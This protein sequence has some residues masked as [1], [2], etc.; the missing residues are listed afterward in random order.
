MKDPQSNKAIYNNHINSKVWLWCLLLK[1][2]YLPLHL[3]RRKL[4]WL[5]RMKRKRR[6]RMKKR[7]RR[8]RERKKAVF[9]RKKT[10]RSSL[11]ITETFCVT[12][13]GFVCTHAVN[14]K[15]TTLSFL[16]L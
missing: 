6:M 8:K 15:P 3:L 14:V 10:M 4:W 5:Q 9:R 13:N 2:M 1:R 7:K 12:D 16:S 11:S